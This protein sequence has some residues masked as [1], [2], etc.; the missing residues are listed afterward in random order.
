MKTNNN[1]PKGG[2]AKETRAEKTIRLLTT[3]AGNPFNQK[4]EEFK[5]FHPAVVTARRNGMKNKQIIKILAEGGLKLY[6]TLF[7]KLMAAMSEDPDATTCTHCGQAL[8][9]PVEG[10]GEACPPTEDALTSTRSSMTPEQGY[11]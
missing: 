9:H 11:S 8:Q 6:P 3:T 10:A 4:L 7:E 2:D 5:A 1:L